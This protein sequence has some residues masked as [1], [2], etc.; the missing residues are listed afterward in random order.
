[1]KFS[2]TEWFPFFRSWRLVGVTPDA[3]EIPDRL[4]PKG[5]VLVGSPERP[6]WVAFDC[7]CGA[8][9]RIMLNADGGRRPFW[10][11]GVH[12]RR[13]TLFPSVDYVGGRK[14]CH[15]FVRNGQIDWVQD[16]ASGRG[17]DRRR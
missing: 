2:W 4:P 12:D 5:V 3:D 8:G 1:M 14:R 7:P 9:H 15:Y 16:N 10:Q 17:G 13:V 11:V 6:K